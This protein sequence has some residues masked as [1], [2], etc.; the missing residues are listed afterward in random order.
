MNGRPQP[1]WPT[2]SASHPRRCRCRGTRCTPRP[3]CS[4]TRSAT[5]SSIGS[6]PTSTIPPTT[7]TGTRSRR[8]TGRTTRAGACRSP[9]R[10]LATG[11]EWN[12]SRT[13]TARRYLGQLGI[14]PG[15]VLDMVK[16]TSFAGPLW[17]EVGNGR[18][19]LGTTLAAMGT[20]TD[21]VSTRREFLAGAGGLALGAVSLGAAAGWRPGS[22]SPQ[23]TATRQAGSVGRRSA[24]APRWT[25]SRVSSTPPRSCATSTAARPRRCPTA[26]CC[27]SGRSS[28]ATRRSRS[29][30][31]PLPR[32]DLQLPSARAHPALHRGRSLAVRF[33]NGS[34]HPH[35][36]HFHGIHPP[37]MDGVPGI[38]P[39]VIAPGTR[40]A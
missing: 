15:T 3:K 33:V 38:S 20:R 17:V 40:A 29:P 7:R 8:R 36:M 1:R 37:E 35:T 16:R 4:S 5:G 13:A 30:R 14:R 19:G 27:V 31:C 28:S 10:S 39:G 18:H 2:S 34:E 12:G 9:R 23:R 22:V 25:T 32:L 26:G 6:T 21:L 24:T 11:S